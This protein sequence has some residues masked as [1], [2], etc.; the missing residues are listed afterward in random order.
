MP[1]AGGRWHKSPIGLQFNYFFL[2][3]FRTSANATIR[4]AAKPIN[5]TLVLVGSF[6][7]SAGTSTVAMSSAV[8][9]SVGSEDVDAISKPHSSFGYPLMP[10][11]KP[12]LALI[13][14]PA[15]FSASAAVCPSTASTSMSPAAVPSHEGAAPTQSA[16]SP[17]DQV[18]SKP[19]AESST[20]PLLAV[21]QY[22]G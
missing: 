14:R 12:S 2:R 22:V 19:H 13:S 4:T 17:E 3:I 10:H 11:T 15:A 7:S 5:C 21:P 18:N 8:A 16:G 20:V 1:S 9:I 6:T